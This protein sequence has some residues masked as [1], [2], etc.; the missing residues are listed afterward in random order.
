MKPPTRSPTIVE[1]AGLAGAGKSTTAKALS[2]C[3]NQILL[4]EPPFYRRIR[5]IPFFV[6]NAFLLL[7]TLFRL[8]LARQGSR[9]LS[10]QEI[11]SMVV[12]LGWHRRLKRLSS[13]HS[14]VIVLDQGPVCSLMLLE[15]FGPEILKSPRAEEWWTKTC[16]RW[17]NTLD[18]VI[19]LDAPT[20]TLVERIRAR[21]N[22]HSVKDRSDAEACKY[23]GRHRESYRHV[24]SLLTAN[25]DLQVLRFD[26]AQEPVDRIVDQLLTEFGL[27]ASRARDVC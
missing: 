21:G 4:G 20:A 5:D 16:R 7:P 1:L 18:T 2:Q 26:T 22:W 15:F 17:A 6:W 25:N 19:W 13:D 10:G 24:L 14:Q 27:T 23:L 11:L 3:G 8:G 12:L 9:W